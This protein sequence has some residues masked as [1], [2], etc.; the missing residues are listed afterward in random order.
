[1]QPLNFYYNP[2]TNHHMTTA[3]ATGNAWAKANGFV[4]QRVEGWVWADGAQD[5]SMTRLEMWYSPARGD[6]FLVGTPLNRAN[7]IGAGYVLQYIDCWAPSEWVLWPDTAPAGIPFPRSGDLGDFSY[8][9]GQ[10]AVTPGIGADTWYPSWAADGNLYSSFTDGTVDGVTSSSWKGAQATTGFA[11]I[12]GDDPFNLT[13]SGVAT[14]EE[15]ATPY[16]GR[17]P[18]VNFHHDGVWYYGTYG[19]LNYQPGISPPPDCGK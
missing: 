19:L 10:N 2:A 12:T 8:S 13:L 18:S 11:T 1:L 5:P 14:W 6:H 7:V 16:E 17:Y 3:S 9:L 4:F 15:P